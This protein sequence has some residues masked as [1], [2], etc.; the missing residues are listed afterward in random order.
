M[1]EK[2]LGKKFDIHGGGMDLV[3]P[4]HEAEITQSNACNNCNP[5]NYWVHNNMVT[6]DGQ[7]MGKSIGNF[8]TLN[9]FF[10]G[11]HKKLEKSYSPM[12]IRFFILQ[13]HY[14]GTIDFSNEA[15]QAA[16]KGLE[17]LISATE[18]LKKI[19]PSNQ[20]SCNVKELKNNC[21]AAMNDDFNTPILLSHLFNQVRIINSAKIGKEQLT[22]DD[23]NQLTSILNL[24]IIDILGFTKNNT[25]N[26][27]DFTTEI[28]DLVL[29]LR[30]T[31]KNNQDFET[32][33][34]IREKLNKVGVEIKDSKDGASWKL[35]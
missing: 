34:L 27:A 30:K 3:F 15:L 10:T 6:I 31:A 16:E 18:T 19:T 13:A 11:T 12:T 4:H 22:L 25:N 2:Y 7:K 14:K 33:D 35:K 26:I 24:F 32:A 17:K 23:I 9:E 21:Y 28:M 5:A 20:S 1:S 8:I 29:D